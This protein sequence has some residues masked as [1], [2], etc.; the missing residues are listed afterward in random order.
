MTSEA[1]YRWK[2]GIRPR[3][4]DVVNGQTVARGRRLSATFRSVIVS[5]PKY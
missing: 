4:S 5:D 2:H 1:R 3:L